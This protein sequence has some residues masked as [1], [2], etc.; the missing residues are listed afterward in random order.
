MCAFVA[1]CFDDVN[2]AR[3]MRNEFN[4]FVRASHPAYSRV[5][6]KNKG[7]DEGKRKETMVQERGEKEKGT[8]VHERNGERERERRTAL[9]QSAF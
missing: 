8:R 7:L 4:D 3:R 9:Q 2:G 5:R 1:N 6:G